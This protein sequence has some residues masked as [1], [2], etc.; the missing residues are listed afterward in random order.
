MI[1]HLVY[2]CHDIDVATRLVEGA[3]GVKMSP[4]GRHPRRGTV[5][6]LLRIGPHTYL[7]LLAI[8][9]TNTDVKPP[10]WMGIDLLPPSSPGRLTR[11]ALA[12][13]DGAAP[14]TRNAFPPFEAGRRRLADGSLL[15]W[16][17]TDPGADPLVTTRPFLI[18][19]EGEPSP[20]QRLP[21]VGCKLH[22]LR[23]YS[24]VVKDLPP[25]VN[26][27]QLL[28]VVEDDGESIEAFISGPG[29]SLRLE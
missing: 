7:E 21:E 26:E 14:P 6:R 5:N 16:R 19:W 1:D 3:L 9:P 18:D 15:R 13:T 2:C 12:V 29:G 17:L 20:A 24:S 4:G 10:R 22:A 25:V 23:I 11:W 8:D 27:I 28:S